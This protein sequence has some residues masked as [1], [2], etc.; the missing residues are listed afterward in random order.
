MSVHAVYQP[1]SC[2]DSATL[3]HLRG[4][5]RFRGS[6][7]QVVFS[8]TGCLRLPLELGYPVVPFAG[9]K[10]IRLAAWSICLSG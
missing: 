6:K 8:Y 9:D 7:R 5:L 3:N 10:R 1:V 4:T 2:C